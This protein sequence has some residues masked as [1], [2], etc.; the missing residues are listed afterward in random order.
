M[1]NLVGWKREK[2][3]KLED[4]SHSNTKTLDIKINYVYLVRTNWHCLGK[5]ISS[6]LSA[7]KKANEQFDADL[8]KM[9]S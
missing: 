6:D 8:N 5:N 7:L 4:A 1:T 2:I 3:G 9:Q